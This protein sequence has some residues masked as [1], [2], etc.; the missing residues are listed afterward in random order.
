MPPIPF[1]AKPKFVLSAIAFYL[2]AHFI[3]RLSMW[4]TL[5]IDDAE[6]ALFAQQF[7]WSYRN[8]APPLFTW[9]LIA[10]G[11]ILGIDIV[12]IS[13]IRYALLGLTF[14]FTYSTARRLIDDPRLSALA[15]YSF[16]AIYM[17]AFYSHHDLTHTTMMTAMLAVAWRVFVRLTE[18]PTL[19]W[20][21]ALGVV[22]GLGLLGKWNFVMFAAALPIA[23]LLLPK[24]RRLAIA[25]KVV[26]AAILCA[27]IVLP[28]AASAFLYGP[29]DMDRIHSVLVGDAGL[30]YP[31]LVLEGTFRLA[32]SAIAYPQPFLILFALVF[33][34][35][36]VRALRE[37]FAGPSP[38]PRRPDAAFLGWTMAISLV[39]HL[40]LVLAIGARE[41]HERL[42]Q[43]ALF[44]LPVFL[45]MLV[46]RGRP[47]PRA[48]NGFALMM[49]ALVPIA[50]AARIVVYEI[51]ADY[52]RSCRN[53]VPFGALADDLK[54]AGFPGNGTIVTEG[55][56][57]GG[58]MRVE[59]P[60]ARVIDAD[61]PP[62]VW[63]APGGSGGCLIV[64]QV[65]E[66]REP[67]RSR[68]ALQSYVVEKLGGSAEAPYRDGAADEL[69]LHSARRYR[70]GYR[71]YEGPNGDCR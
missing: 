48:V 65:R 1:W 62:S 40:A 68:T 20:Y 60:A 3:V 56:H 18:R 47:S 49:A 12:S 71:L 41:F 35:P 37:E 29:S 32:L 16:A 30:S 22:G 23:C 26:P 67:D 7:A 55:F 46:D 24:Y 57:I 64:W 58:N 33:A 25:W 39:L 34:L 69:M 5:G 15:I 31:S 44:I 59:F 42:M 36:L 70:L 53:M 8:S 38:P 21:L 19:G 17:F 2:L 13:L 54:A 14:A 52:C 10:L 6:Q 4:R 11:K 43:P 63:P 51:G 61:Y 9:T 28:T 27:A 50:L 66:D 45:F